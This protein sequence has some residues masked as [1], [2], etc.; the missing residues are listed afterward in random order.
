M[1]DPARVPEHRLLAYVR[2]RA[3]GLDAQRLRTRVRAAAAELEAALTGLDEGEARQAVLAGEWTVAQIVD[4]VA[5]STVRAA[6]ELRHLREGRRPPGPPVYEALLSGAAHRVPWTELVG[7][8]RDASAA[9]DAV[10]AG[11][12]PAADPGVVTAP[13]VLVVSAPETGAG[14]EIFTAELTWREYALVQR[15]HFLEHRT[16][17]RQLRAALTAPA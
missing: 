6:E 1:S 16:Q 12:E 2:T 10:L 15:L 13:A 9:L 17:V 14:P 8:L 7:G 3:A 5:Q 4:H 11:G